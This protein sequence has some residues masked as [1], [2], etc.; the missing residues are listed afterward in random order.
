MS[1]GFIVKKTTGT[2][3]VEPAIYRLEGGGIIHYATCPKVVP[4]AAD[5]ELPRESPQLRGGEQFVV[6]SYL[7]LA[8]QLSN[9]TTPPRIRQAPSSTLVSPEATSSAGS[10]ADSSSAGGSGSSTPICA[11]YSIAP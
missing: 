6:L 5:S 10:S 8:S 1:T 4:I 7:C 3:G 2:A 9:Y 11:R